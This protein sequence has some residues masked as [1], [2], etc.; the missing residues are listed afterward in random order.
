MRGGYLRGNLKSSKD[1]VNIRLKTKSTSLKRK[2]KV[3]EARTFTPI[4]HTKREQNE[5][6]TPA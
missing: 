5:Y 1:W 6:S 4:R 3:K 2:A